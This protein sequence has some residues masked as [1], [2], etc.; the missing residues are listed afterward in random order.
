MNEDLRLLLLSN[1]VEEKE[2]E[3]IEKLYEE[4]MKEQYK[5]AYEKGV[6]YGKEISSN[7]N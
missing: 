6:K 5:K 3:K 4:V 7:L 1:G 2:L